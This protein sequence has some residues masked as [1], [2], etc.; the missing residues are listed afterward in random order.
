MSKKFKKS[1]QFDEIISDVIGKLSAVPGFDVMIQDNEGAKLFDFIARRFS[2]LARLKALYLNS[3]IPAVNKNIA[4]TISMMNSSVYCNELKISRAEIKDT[5]YE[6]VRLGYVHLFNSMEG[7]YSELLTIANSIVLTD[8]G[9]MTIQRWLEQHCNI[10]IEKNW[11]K[12]HP[13][14][15]K[16]NW[17]ANS[18]KHNDGFPKEDSRPKDRNEAQYPVGMRIQIEGKEFQRDIDASIQMYI[19]YMQYVFLFKSYRMCVASRD[20]ECVKNNAALRN[21]LSDLESQMTK[22]IEL[23]KKEKK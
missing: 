13:L 19:L 2:N 20:D 15:E 17:I 5:Y 1:N 12:V 8:D 22:F 21:K 4:D 14:A 9:E 7:Y 10:N 18:V 16:I 23:F 11:K 6:V 3:F